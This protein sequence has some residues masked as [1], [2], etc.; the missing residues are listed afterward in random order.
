MSFIRNDWERNYL[1][2]LE[3]TLHTFS[4][5]AAGLDTAGDF[6]YENINDL[7]MSGYTKLT[8]SEEFGGLGKGLYEYLLVQEAIARHCGSTALAIGWHV[9]IVLQLKDNNRGWNK[10]VFNEVM[11]KVSKGALINR[12]ASE[13]ATGSPS[14]G[15]IPTTTAKLVDGKWILNGRKNY[16]SLAPVLNLI[17]VSAWIPEREQLGWFLI[18]RDTPGVEI[19]KT[20]NVISMQGT[21][22]EDLLLNNVEVDDKYL[23]ETGTHGVMY[24][25][26]WL[27]HIPACYIGIAGAARN[28][29]ID[30]AKTHSPNSISGTISEL[31]N[32]KMKIGKMELELIK[33]RHFLY[34]VASQW[35]NQ[36]KNHEQLRAQL[37]A[38][39]VAVTNSAL[40]IVDLSMRIV[41][42]FSLQKSCPLQRYYR[43][44]RA[45]LHNPPMDDVVI[46]LLAQASFEEYENFQ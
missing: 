25:D 27:L 31:P 38:V 35:I 14:R 17:I 23:V 45:G 40:S 4:E 43:D 12:A 24:D 32:V 46:Q 39:K 2:R 15:G 1:E 42:A 33:S 44:V 9:G 13:P 10:D 11:E 7:I 41:G 16:T 37:G 34:S 6:P 3:P 36:P 21:G 28:F 5:R 29:A 30:F 18:D 8:L 20:W 22:S 19:K 26:S